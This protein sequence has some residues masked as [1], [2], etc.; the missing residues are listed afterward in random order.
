MWVGLYH[1][2][3]A[4]YVLHI[5]TEWSLVHSYTNFRYA[6]NIFI[7]IREE[8][9]ETAQQQKCVACARACICTCDEEGGKT[10]PASGVTF[11][12]LCNTSF[13]DNSKQ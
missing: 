9:V 2:H 10:P 11:S 7:L 3:P 1:I 4:A 5:S 12:D 6:E 8:R 13:H